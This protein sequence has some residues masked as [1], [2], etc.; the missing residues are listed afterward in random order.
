M[1]EVAL[2][3]VEDGELMDVGA[4]QVRALALSRRRTATPPSGIMP[5][6]PVSSHICA[7]SERE[8]QVEVGVA[9]CAGAVQTRCGHV[10]KGWLPINVHNRAGACL[11]HRLALTKWIWQDAAQARRLA[12][13]AF[14]E[15]F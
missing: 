6:R 12:L 14:P 11:A 10:G 4:V 2:A 7:H 9:E 3:G 8:E 13:F 15:N 5:L 1:R